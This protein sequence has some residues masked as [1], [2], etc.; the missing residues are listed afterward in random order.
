MTA[1]SSG[2]IEDIGAG[3]MRVDTDSDTDP[4][5]GCQTEEILDNRCK[6]DL[7]KQFLIDG[8]T[9]KRAVGIF[10]AALI[11]NFICE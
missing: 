10:P 9:A 6:R 2:R 11:C 7:S 8:I 5:C 1:V 3:D 4:R